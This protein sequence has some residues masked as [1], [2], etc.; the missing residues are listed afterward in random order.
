L[1]CWNEKEDIVLMADD[2][3]YKETVKKIMHVGLLGKVQNVEIFDSPIHFAHF[4]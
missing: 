3:L 4:R 1:T 2:D